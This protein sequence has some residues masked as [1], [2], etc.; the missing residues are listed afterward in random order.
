MHL[1]R[2]TTGRAS[3]ARSTLCA[4]RE[5]GRLRNV[6]TK[7]TT[8]TE[9]RRLAT[10]LERQ[11]ERARFG[12]EPLPSDST[13]TLG[14][15]CTWWLDERCPEASVAI[16][17]QRLGKHVLRTSLGSLPLR[18]VTTAAIES[19][20]REME[21]D[22]LGPSSVNSL[23]TTLHTV[24]TQARKAGLWTGANPAARRARCDTLSDLGS[25]ADFVSPSRCLRMATPRP[26]TGRTT[27]G[28]CAHRQARGIASG[29]R[30]L[31]S[32]HVR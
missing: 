9:A 18:H 22:D 10:D 29:R 7:A 27:G 16:E 25:G 30:R 2:D 4:R 13:L 31:R 12:L 24:Y 20:L 5:Q 26:V 8:K 23:R 14:Q 17:T 19:R 11:A 21:R 28:R 15:L 1:R 3:S 32:P 6:A